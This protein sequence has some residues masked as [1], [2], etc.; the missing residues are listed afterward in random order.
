MKNY[1]GTIP[2]IIVFLL[3]AIWVVTG[4]FF[5]FHG[6][7]LQD[8]KFFHYPTAL[9]FHENPIW[10]AINSS[11]YGPANTPL[12]YIIIKYL[13]V[14]FVPG[15]HFC[16]FISFVFSVF[17]LFFLYKIIRLSDI[18]ENNLFPLFLILFFPYFLKSSLTFYMASF[19]LFFGFLSVYLFLVLKNNPVR[20]FFSGLAASLAIL[21][22]QFYIA[23]PL[24]FIADSILDFIKKKEYKPLFVSFISLTPLIL[25][26]AVFIS[27]GGLTH[28]KYQLA[29]PVFSIKT[30]IFK[31]LPV[32]NLTSVLTIIGFY[33]IPFSF[34]KIREIKLKWLLPIILLCLLLSVFNIPEYSSH[35]GFNKITGLVHHLLQLSESI[36]TYAVIPLRFIL[37]FSGMICL[38]FVFSLKKSKIGSFLKW[39]LLFFLFIFLGDHFLSERHLLAMMVLLFVF[40]KDFYIHKNIYT[41][42]VVLMA[43]CGLIYTIQWFAA[44]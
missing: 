34:F 23:I 44:A 37:V 36:F 14:G 19:G 29:S 31:T 5:I 35:Q 6:G 42:W 3:P 4:I 15:I 21:C 12:P 28:P 30:D 32:R 10:S 38:Y 1:K 16:R 40:L 41:G 17:S 7:P 20:C 33:F 39:L 27:W 8:E 24:A 43:V 26:L 13:S 25:P 9:L 22:Q 18:S 2:R 11:Q